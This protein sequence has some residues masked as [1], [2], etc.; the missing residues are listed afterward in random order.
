MAIKGALNDENHLLSDWS[1]SYKKSRL[2]FIISHLHGNNEKMSC[3]YPQ[4]HILYNKSVS[5]NDFIYSQG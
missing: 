5:K 2:V 3:I 1:F 4:L